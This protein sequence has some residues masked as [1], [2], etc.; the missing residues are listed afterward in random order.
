MGDCCACYADK[1]D[2]ARADDDLARY[3]RDGP[4]HT[5]RLLL[6]ALRAEGVADATLLDVGGGVGV[7]QHEL[8]AAGVRETVA[9]DASRAY[10]SAARGE[11]ERRGTADRTT[12]LHGDFVALA[13]EIA[14]ADIVT[15]D[16]VICCY[17]DMDVLVAASAS[18]ARRL[19][20]I[21]VPRDTW[22][23]RAVEGAGNLLRRLQRRDFRSYI[24]RLA[25]IDAAVLAQGLHRCFSGGTLK[26]QV[27][28][29]VR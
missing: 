14:T 1:F 3:R 18:R 27:W 7:V 12:F 25:D 11:A 4:S 22:W 24:H 6:D 19:Y 16:R 29:Y 8:L 23:V 20:G 21:V 10:L 13:P 2:D 26:W 15:L 17:P 5:T 28:V 9:V